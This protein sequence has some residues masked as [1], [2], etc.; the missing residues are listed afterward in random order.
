VTRYS[1]AKCVGHILQRNCLLKRVFE[2]NI[3]E[4][5]R[6]TERQGRRIKQLLASLNKGEG[7]LN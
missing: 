2:G 1:E 3:E 5:S 7:A 6:E 4:K